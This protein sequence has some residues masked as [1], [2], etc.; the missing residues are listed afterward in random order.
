MFILAVRFDTQTCVLF[1]INDK[2]I[3]TT[4]FI[5][6]AKMYAAIFVDTLCGEI[7]FH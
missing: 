5:K 7:I 4:E 2:I 6:G 1:I 3:L